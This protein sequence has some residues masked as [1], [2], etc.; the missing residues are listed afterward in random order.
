MYECVDEYKEVGVILLT[1]VNDGRHLSDPLCF[2]KLKNGI[3][4]KRK[5]SIFIMLERC[6]FIKDI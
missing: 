6:S 4:L 3:E 2:Y 5:L 1:M